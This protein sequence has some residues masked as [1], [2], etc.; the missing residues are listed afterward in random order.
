VLEVKEETG[1]GFRV[2]K[3]LRTWSETDKNNHVAGIT[4]L[5]QKAKGKFAISDEHTTYE[6][7]SRKEALQRRL[8]IWLRDELDF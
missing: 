8:P 5:A 2:I 7:V 6:W 3:P 4:F 1:L